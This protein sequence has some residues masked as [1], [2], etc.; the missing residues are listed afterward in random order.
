MLPPEVPVIWSS[1]LSAVGEC[2]PAAAWSP[3][4]TEPLR[5]KACAGTCVMKPL[6]DLV[7]ERTFT[8]LSKRRATLEDGL[9]SD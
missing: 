1:F 6:H 4:V 9:P 8:V 5:R 3:S 2:M 7:D